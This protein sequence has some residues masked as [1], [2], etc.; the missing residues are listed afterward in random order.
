MENQIQKTGQND[1]SAE[2]PKLKAMELK[3]QNTVIIDGKPKK[4]VQEKQLLL[5]KITLALVAALVA[6]L[7][8]V[9]LVALP[10]TVKL[11]DSVGTTIEQVEGTLNE[12]TGVIEDIEKAVGDATEIIGSIDVDGINASIDSLNQVSSSLAGIF[13][14]FK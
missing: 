2:N 3:E 9:A 6:L 11:I 4:T 10:K 12:A 8:I 5:S 1:V 14:I 7:L 13:K